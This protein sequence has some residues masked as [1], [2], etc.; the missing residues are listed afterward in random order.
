MSDDWVIKAEHISKKFTRSLKRSMAYGLMDTAKSM[1]GLNIHEDQLRKG[2]FWALDDISFELKKGESLGLIGRNGCG[3]STLLR[4]INGIYPPSR[5]RISI[6]GRMGALIA[7]GAG[8]HPHMTGYENIYLN[9]TILGMSRAEIDEKIDQII[10][11]SEIGEFIQAPVF[12]Y[13]SGMTVRLGFAIAAHAHVDILLADEVLAVGDAEFRRKCHT[14]LQEIKERGT[15]IILVSHD[16]SALLSN[17]QRGL[18]VKEGRLVFQGAIDEAINCYEHDLLSLQQL[19]DTGE[20]IEYAKNPAYD[21]MVTGVRFDKE[22]NELHQLILNSGDNLTVYIDYESHEQIENVHIGFELFD[23]NM[24][25][26]FFRT[27]F[28][29]KYVTVGKEKGTLILTIADLPF[30]TLNL[31]FHISVLSKD[32]P[33]FWQTNVPL[34]FKGDARYRGLIKRP[35][36]FVKEKA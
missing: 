19:S 4:L 32:A 10:E 17:C 23:D 36:T 6:K 1:I 21:F 20:K 5:G 33:L 12:T 16:V 25:Y 3:K 29:E 28:F 31:R 15:S 11:F 18:Y 2:E 14:K 9:G 22:R 27:G 24:T 30:K 13:S 34:L 8:F 35:F 7:V 26:M